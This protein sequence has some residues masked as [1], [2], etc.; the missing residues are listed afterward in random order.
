MFFGAIVGF[1]VFPML[2][3]SSVVMRWG[4]KSRPV[5]YRRGFVMLTSMSGR[6]IATASLRKLLIYLEEQAVA[7]GRN[8][9]SATRLCQERNSH[10]MRL[11]QVPPEVCDGKCRNE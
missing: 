10:W 9:T 5:R 7:V 1:I 2:V 6:S 11:T 3:M 4:D 8:V